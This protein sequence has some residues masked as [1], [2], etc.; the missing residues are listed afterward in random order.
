MNQ[1]I[2]PQYQ[3]D[4]CTSITSMGKNPIK[5]RLYRLELYYTYDNGFE[6]CSR[7]SFIQY[8]SVKYEEDIEQF[9]KSGE[10]RNIKWKHLDHDMR[11]K[12]PVGEWFQYEYV[13]DLK[14]ETENNF[15]IIS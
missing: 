13:M 3:V 12:K 7:K 11:D 5:W 9:H 10:F 4:Q 8:A 6:K 2:T 14:D 15:L 1:F